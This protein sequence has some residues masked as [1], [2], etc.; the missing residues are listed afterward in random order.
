MTIKELRDECKNKGLKTTGTKEELSLRLKNP[1]KEDYTNDTDR[2]RVNLG[3]GDPKK[4]LMSSLIEKGHAK[5]LC[6]A[7][8]IFTYEVDKEKWSEVNK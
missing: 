2:I 5:F 3:W 1:K 4:T 6:Y 8:D 7:T